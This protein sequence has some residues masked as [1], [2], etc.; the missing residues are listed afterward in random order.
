MERAFQRQT[1]TDVGGL[2]E[3][4]KLPGLYDSSLTT[5]NRATD[6]RRGRAL[7]H[8]THPT[9]IDMSGNDV[10]AGVDVPLYYA[11]EVTGTVGG[12]GVAEHFADLGVE[13]AVFDSGT[14]SWVGTGDFY[15][16]AA[17]GS[18]S[19]VTDLYPDDYRLWARYDGQLGERSIISPTISVPIGGSLD[20]D[21][22]E[23]LPAAFSFVRADF[24]GEAVPDLL[25]RSVSGDLYLFRGDGASGWD[26]QS[27][28]RAG[29]GEVHVRGSRGRP[30]RRWVLRRSGSQRARRGL[31]LP[32]RRSGWM[33]GLCEGRIGLDGIYCYRRAR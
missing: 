26:G 12:L 8:S 15:P 9:L 2:Y 5:T 13:V 4:Y 33:A 30:E 16:V 23:L 22:A 17:D 18:M 27:L 28:R 7:A 14:R 21:F 11:G 19:P 3:A 20:F 29:V 24:T 1:T 6:G 10:L 31:P 32:R 25:A